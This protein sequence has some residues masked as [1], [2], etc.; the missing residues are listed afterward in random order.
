MLACCSPAWPLRGLPSA[1]SVEPPTPP[2]RVVGVTTIVSDGEARSSVIDLSVHGERA[3]LAWIQSDGGRETAAWAELDEDG[4]PR[5]RRAVPFVPARFAIVDDRALFVR[6]DERG[7]RACTAPLDGEA[8]L[9]CE[10]VS[11]DGS[12]R[13]S[14]GPREL[15]LD[16]GTAVVRYAPS[17]GRPSIDLHAASAR[18]PFMPERTRVGPCDEAWVVAHD[19]VVRVLHGADLAQIDPR[20]S[21]V[22]RGARTFAVPPG[23]SLALDLCSGRRLTVGASEADHVLAAFTGA[24]GLALV[25][26]RAF[27]DG[28][29]WYEYAYGGRSEILHESDSQDASAAW[30]SAAHVDAQGRLWLVLTQGARLWIE[31]RTTAG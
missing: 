15:A 20:S 23:A 24:S 9:D 16:F 12:A 3:F 11:P 2:L 14:F 8:P 5:W 25:R 7:I 27:D 10:L 22:V 26:G 6:I 21:I 1:R 31:I 4:A 17:S 30:L 28:P 13:V 18:S 19:G 29:R